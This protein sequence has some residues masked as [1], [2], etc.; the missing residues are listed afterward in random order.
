VFLLDR[1]GRMIEA[2]ARRQD[3]TAS[4]DDPDQE[5]AIEQG[6]HRPLPNPFGPASRSPSVR[7]SILHRSRTLGQGPPIVFRMLPKCASMWARRMRLTGSSA[8]TLETL[9]VYSRPRALG[10]SQV[11]PSWAQIWAQTQ[12]RENFEAGNLLILVVGRDGIEPPTP[13]FS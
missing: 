7:G 3:R 1:P 9:V 2:G 5:I 6:A 10:C 4:E 13:G 8:V 11:C 12:S